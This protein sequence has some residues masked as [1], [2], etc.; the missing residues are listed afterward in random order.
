MK[1]FLATGITV[2]FCRL[3]LFLALLQSR[4]YPF[5][6]RLLSSFS[7]RVRNAVLVIIVMIMIVYK[8]MHYAD[9]FMELHFYLRWRNNTTIWKI[10][11]F[12]CQVYVITHANKYT[13]TYIYVVPDEFSTIAIRRNLMI[14]QVDGITSSAKFGNELDEH[15]LDN[16]IVK[17]SVF[18]L[19]W[20]QR[21]NNIHLWQKS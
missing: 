15:L 12:I 8:L 17:W 6:S 7:S 1:C 3:L 16:G 13:H 18:A 21:K 19:K 10:W 9:A 11:Y 2:L 5:M 14:Q 4:L 20:S